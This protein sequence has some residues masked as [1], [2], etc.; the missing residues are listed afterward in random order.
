MLA[1]TAVVSVAPTGITSAF[2][3]TFTVAWAMLAVTVVVS[4]SSSFLV[5]VVPLRVV[6]ESSLL[7]RAAPS[8]P[9][10]TRPFTTSQSNSA[11]VFRSAIIP[12]ST[13]ETAVLRAPLLV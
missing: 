6:T 11:P 8:A 13:L 2:T 1:E 9:S 4:A 5:A 10:F 3:T 7:S 12:A